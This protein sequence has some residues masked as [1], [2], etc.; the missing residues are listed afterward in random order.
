LRINLG[1]EGTGVPR[2]FRQ[3]PAVN[4]LEPGQL[5]ISSL[6]NGVDLW[7]TTACARPA[8]VPTRPGL[9]LAALPPIL[10]ALACVGLTALAYELQYRGAPNIR[11]LARLVISLVAIFMT[12]L[13]ALRHPHTGAVDQRARRLRAGADPRQRRRHGPGRHRTLFFEPFFSTKAEGMGW[14]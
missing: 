6:E 5:K 13:L 11:P 12:A 14:A 7:G 10:L 9:P 2:L 1:P 3:L 4:G 8:T